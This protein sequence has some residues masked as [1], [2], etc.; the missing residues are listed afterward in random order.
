MSGP[1]CEDPTRSELWPSTNRVVSQRIERATMT[2]ALARARLMGV[3]LDPG[4]AT[5]M[6]C[7]WSRREDPLNWERAR[8]HQQETKH[9]ILVGPI[10]S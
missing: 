6:G 10:L 1:W 9:A 3:E 7:M 5:C 2:D 8:D 4:S